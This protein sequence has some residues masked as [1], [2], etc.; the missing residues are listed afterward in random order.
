[1]ENTQNEPQVENRPPK[2]SWI[3]RHRLV[4]AVIAILGILIITFLL[5]TFLPVTVDDTSVSNPAA[6]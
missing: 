2:K 5:L 3:R 6:E 1:M 4:T